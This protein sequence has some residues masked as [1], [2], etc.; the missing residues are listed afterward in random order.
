MGT[1]KLERAA[2][3]AYFDRVS[4]HLTA[5]ETEIR[6][7]GADLGAQVEAEHMLLTGFSYDPGTRSFEVSGDDL[8][9]R[10]D[11]P[12]EIYVEEEGTSLRSIQVTDRDGHKQIIRLEPMLTLPAS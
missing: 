1:R 9:H 10:V 8:A 4:K 5:S 6:V 11:D 3:Q 2:W 7:T 12:E